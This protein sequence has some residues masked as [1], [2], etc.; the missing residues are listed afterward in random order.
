MFWVLGSELTRRSSEARHRVEQAVTERLERIVDIVFRY[1]GPR[2]ILART[3]P[4]GGAM[5]WVAVLLAVTLVIYYWRGA[6]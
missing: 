2:G 1:H 4:T 6:G 5:V 3:S